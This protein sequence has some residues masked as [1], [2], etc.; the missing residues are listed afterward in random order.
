[1]GRRLYKLG[2]DT[3]AKGE[4]FEYHDGEKEHEE[5]YQIIVSLLSLKTLRDYD[6]GR[7]GEFYFK[8][9]RRHMWLRAPI[10]GTI[11]LME[12]Q[13]FT[14]R[15]DF[16][17][18]V[19]MLELDKGDSKDIELDIELFERDIGKMDK[20]VFDLK[21]PIRAGTQTKYQVLEDEKQQTKAKVKIAA[22]RTRY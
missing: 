22:M 10:I 1:M 8:V 2:R 21:L 12:N 13:V 18:W 6:I 9:K 19:E 4:T 11:N 7:G 14:A 16:S 20:K 3:Y 5:R 15:Q 17:L